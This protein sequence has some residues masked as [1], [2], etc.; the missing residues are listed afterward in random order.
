[1]EEKAEYITGGREDKDYLK[2]FDQAEE[3]LESVSI[4]PADERDM[5]L[6]KKFDVKAIKTKRRANAE[7]LRRAFP[8]WLIFPTLAPTDIPM[9][10]PVLVPDGK[11]D[12]LRRYLIQNEIYCPIHWPVSEYHKLDERTAHIYQNELSLVCDQRYTEEDM[13][14]MV[15]MINVFWK[16]A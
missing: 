7:V 5:E 2:V 16:E 9:F 15:D 1:M 3:L 6:A 13:N 10:V 14:R 8:D 4:S 12:A 11:R